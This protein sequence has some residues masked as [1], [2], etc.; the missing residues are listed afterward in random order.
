MSVLGLLRFDLGISRLFDL[1]FLLG[2]VVI[3]LI[4]DLFRLGLIGLESR[5]GGLGLTFENGL[6]EL[7]S[8]LIC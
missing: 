3:G 2:L 6:V 8:N 7:G 5:L 4:V 1:G